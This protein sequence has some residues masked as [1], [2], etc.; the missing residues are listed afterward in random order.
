M[1]TLD[2]RDKRLIFLGFIFSVAYCA[3]ELPLRILFL[4][5]CF[6]HPPPPLSPFSPFPL[7]SVC[8]GVRMCYKKELVCVCCGAYYMLLLSGS[9]FLHVLFSTSCLLPTYTSL[10]PSYFMFP[11]SSPLSM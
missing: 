1:M 3:D 5:F 6:C 8:H 4:C 9:F 11:F 7:I 2:I 10:A